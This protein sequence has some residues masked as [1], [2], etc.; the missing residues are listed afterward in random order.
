MAALQDCW[1][2]LHLVEHPQ[3]RQNWCREAATERKLSNFGEG[4]HVLLDRSDFNVEEKLAVRW[5]GPCWVVKALDNYVFRVQVLRNGQLDIAH[6]N[7]Q[8]LYTDTALDL[9]QIMP[10]VLSSWSVM[11]VACLI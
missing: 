10:H 11:H 3:N 9:Q 5:N 7:L 4:N 1:A 8:E 6:G 2:A